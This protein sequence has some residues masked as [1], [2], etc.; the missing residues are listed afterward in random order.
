MAQ[1]DTAEN[2]RNTSETERITQ[3]IWST[4]VMTGGSDRRMQLYYQLIQSLKKADSVDI[5][6]SFLM[7][8]GVKMLLEELD[9]ALKRGA[10]IRIL[11]GNYLGITQP[12]ALY[13]LKKKLGSR[14]DMRFYNEKERSFHPKSYIF[15][16]ERYSDIYIGSSNIS[17]SAL[18]SG[19]EWNY[20]F[21]SVSDPKNY[22]KFYQVFEDLF[23]HHSIIIDN[24][25]LKRYSQN[26]HRPAVAKDLERYEYSHQNEENESEDTKVRLLYEPRGAQIEALCALED[27]RAEGA[28]RAL[29]QA[30]TGVG[31][32]YLAAF[33]SKSYERV[34]FVAHREEILKQAAASFRNVR[35][36][37]DYGFFTGEEKSTD[38]SVIFA[39]VATLGRSE[40]LSE[41]YFAP[42]Y[43]QYLVIDEFHH[44]VNEQYQRIVKYF[45][46]QFLLGL[47]AT[48]ERMDGRN[49]Y[50]LCDYNVPYEISLKD[51]I[52]KGMLVP[53]HY[54][55]IYDDTDYSG[56]HLI[57]GRYDEKELNETYIGNV[58]RHDLIYKY[59]CKY[60]SK[61]ALGFCCS[62]A[63]AEEMAKEF[64][65]RGI[66]S[67]AVYS[68]ANGT[69]S[70]ERGKAIEKLKS[71]EIRVIF[72]VDMFN[73]GVDITSVD[74]V[75]FLRPT[76]SPIVFLQQLGRGLRRS[77]GKEY[78]NVLDF[79]GNYEK[80]GR[81]RFLLTGR[82][83]GENEYYNPA[84]R[85]VFPDDCLIDFDMKLIDLFSEMDKKHL[86]IKDQIRNEYYRVKE[87]LGRIPSRMDL[88]TYMD[89]D[90]YRVA[91]T[92]SKDNPFKRYLDFRKELGE[93]TE[94]ENL[95]YSGIGR[96]FINLIENTNMSKVYKMPVLMAFYNHGN[97]RSQVSEEELL[98]SW[99]E[100]F[101]TGTNWKD[102]DRGITYEKYCSISDKEHIK[103]I[104]QM[105]VHFLQESGKGFFVKKEGTALALKEDLTDVILQ[106]AF[107][108]QM[109]DV[110]EYRAMDYYRRRYEEKR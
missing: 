31:K 68:N 71:G 42:D 10:K 5:I 74:M 84:D 29:V 86:K 50:E 57:R 66:P 58:H 14:V 28:K 87:L 108:E 98:D 85:S 44:A 38:K 46:P 1:S 59:Y 81:V 11:T 110:I 106:P 19:I 107:G 94:E 40:Y 45:K 24:E 48:P 4:D 103:K 53:F 6:V 63:H 39:S 52:N 8:S 37:E 56:L 80:A 105:P 32:T 79:I 49:I 83:L 82:T 95:L 17:R 78:L 69:Y 67:V 25:E 16:Y 27:T 100:F 30:A 36:S 21:S 12:S 47:T 3:E 9:N 91:I 2:L 65:E 61:K 15:H 77:K 93:L 43:F 76:E 7:E 99:K 51:A 88:F 104:L 97:I 101:S 18:T 60:G 96:E 64:C 102:L 13:L 23:E 109:K 70:E 34:L 26:W 89:D 41:K 55:G 92:H 20:R 62:R 22:E 73:E 35:N 90:I 72:S 75:M 33:D 54:Y